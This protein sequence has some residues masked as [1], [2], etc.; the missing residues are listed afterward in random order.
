MT[1]SEEALRDSVA[2]CVFRRAARGQVGKIIRKPHEFLILVRIVPAR[3]FDDSYPDP[4]P[5]DHLG[6]IHAEDSNQSFRFCT[7][8]S[9]G[10]IWIDAH[11]IRREH[12]RGVRK[13][14]YTLSQITRMTRIQQVSILRRTS[15]L[16]RLWDEVIEI[17]FAGHAPPLFPDQAVDTAKSEFIT[18][19]GM[20]GADVGIAARTMSPVMRRGRIS[21]RV[22][23]N[24]GGHGCLAVADECAAH[25]RSAV[26][27]PRRNEH[28]PPVPGRQ[29]PVARRR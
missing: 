12:K 22:R 17:K 23:F 18:E 8:T 26:V 11:R 10:A 27:R 9:H 3:K 5:S 6:G 19:P 28:L 20:V 7:H 1:P 15:G 25:L 24:R 14:F 13:F 16:S 4:P 29:A 2:F 21:K